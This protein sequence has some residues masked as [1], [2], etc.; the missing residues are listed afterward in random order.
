MQLRSDLA[1]F[2][3]SWQTEL[4][5]WCIFKCVCYWGMNKKSNSRKPL[6]VHLSRAGKCLLVSTPAPFGEITMTL[7]FNCNY[8]C[9][10]R[11]S[12]VRR[13]RTPSHKI[14]RQT[15][16]CICTLSR[17]SLHAYFKTAKDR[18]ERDSE[19]L[20]CTLA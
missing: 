16:T 8:L 20:K 13:S 4:S 9:I 19:Q 18:S 11:H 3:V 15:Q 10:C 6:E 17:V 1:G 14:A 7:R 2:H 12:S 5:L